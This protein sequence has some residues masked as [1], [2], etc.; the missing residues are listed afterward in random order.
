MK[1]H[2]KLFLKNAGKSKNHESSSSPKVES[3]TPLK[4]PMAETKIRSINIALHKKT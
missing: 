4:N 2:A 1:K 3:N